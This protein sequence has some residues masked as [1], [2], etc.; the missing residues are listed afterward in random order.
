MLDV[1]I[2]V[3]S[4]GGVQVTASGQGF[5]AHAR[6]ALDCLTRARDVS[7][8]LLREERRSK[9]PDTDPAIDTDNVADEISLADLAEIT[10]SVLIA[11]IE[12][13]LTALRTSPIDLALLPV[14]R[15]A[16]CGIVLERSKSKG[17]ELID[18]FGK[19]DGNP[20]ICLFSGGTI[21]GQEQIYTADRR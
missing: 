11:I 1:K 16:Q 14:A 19:F 6:E 10:P 12:A 18:L 5:I 13:L 3:R 8:T 15:D 4:S 2:F 7:F 17:A 21:G 9:C 20:L